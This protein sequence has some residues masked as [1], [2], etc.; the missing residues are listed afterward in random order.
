MT[1]EVEGLGK[2]A[3][4]AYREHI[5]H[6]SA[7]TGLGI[8]PWEALSDEVREACVAAASA[9]LK[10]IAFGVSP[11]LTTQRIPREMAALDGVEVF[12]LGFGRAA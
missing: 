9:V 10:E 6:K 8:P 3:Y 11:D 2:V 7:I 1:I 4:T 5:N 12:G